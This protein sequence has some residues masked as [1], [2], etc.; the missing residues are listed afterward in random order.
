MNNVEVTDRQ[1]VRQTVS[2]CFRLVVGLL[3]EQEVVF[4]NISSFLFAEEET[5]HRT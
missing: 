5:V 4:L 3:I 1:T 2:F